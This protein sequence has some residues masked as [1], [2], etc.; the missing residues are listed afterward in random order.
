MDKAKLGITIQLFG[1]GLYFLGLIGITPLVIAAGYVL[2]M[3]EN[4]WIRRVA[5]KAVAVVIF[6]AIFSNLVGLLSE[7]TAFLNNLFLL[8]NRTVNMAT[9]NR[10]IA[11]LRITVSVLQTITLLLLGLNALRMSDYAVGSVDRTIS[12]NM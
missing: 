5:V 3:E 4:Q 9:L 1:A 10:I 12:K 7:G 11:L 2:I 8:F 6:F